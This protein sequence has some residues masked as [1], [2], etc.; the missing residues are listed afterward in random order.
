MPLPFHLAAENAVIFPDAVPEGGLSAA[1]DI[2]IR[3]ACFNALLRRYVEYC[4]ANQKISEES[5]DYQAGCMSTCSKVLEA[6]MTQGDLASGEY[7]AMLEGLQAYYGSVCKEG[8]D[9]AND[10]VTLLA[11][12]AD[13]PDADQFKKIV[14]LRNAYLTALEDLKAKYMPL[15]KQNVDG[16]VN[17]YGALLPADFIQTL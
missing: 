14:E 8:T 15:F 13:A 3:S 16:I 7:E 10:V 5:E 11:A 17:R 9:F 12:K 2:Q 4:K 1:L 6:A